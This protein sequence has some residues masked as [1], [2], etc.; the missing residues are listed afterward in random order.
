MTATARQSALQLIDRV[1]FQQ[2]SLRQIFPAEKARLPVG[3]AALLQELCYGCLR[4]WGSLCT[5][6]NHLLNKPLRQHEHTLITLIN[7]GLYQLLLTRQAPHAVVHESVN[8]AQQQGKKWAK[9]LV[10]AVLRRAQRDAAACRAVLEDNCAAN[11]PPELRHYLN[12]ADNSAYLQRYTAAPLFT[13]RVRAALPIPPVLP[14]GTMN[15]LHPQAYTLDSACPLSELAAFTEGM[16]SVQDASAMWAASLLDV[17]DDMRV[18]DAC[19]AP[20]GKS[21]HI[22]ELAPQAQ[23]VALDCDAARLENV[24]A[25]LVR[26]H[27]SA[28]LIA[29]DLLK[30]Q[31]Q[32]FDRILLDAPCSASGIMHRQPDIAWLRRPQ[33]FPQF[34][35]Q[36]RAMLAHC[37][38]LLRPQGQLLYTTCSIAECENEANI[39]AFLAQHDDAQVLP[40]T[41]PMSQQQTYGCQR[42][43][44][45]Y[46]DGFYYA[47]LLKTS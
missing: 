13:L 19:A 20:G 1:I 8:M 2:E 46:G 7:L 11:L 39:A 44:D 29:V 4:H 33:D 14:A 28:Q 40:L 9:N 35:T 38:T 18:L 37:W 45:A 41:V 15:P 27:Q 26:M 10:N 21:T 32:S 23:L 22:L 47:K 3:Q 6:Q 43:P 17:R 5:L 25:N 34:A 30:Y 31:G 12:I 42:L 24:A 36:Q 16:V